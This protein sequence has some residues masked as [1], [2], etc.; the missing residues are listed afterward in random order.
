MLLDR[1]QV[2]AAG[3]AARQLRAGLDDRL[4]EPAAVRLLMDESPEPAIVLPAQVVRLLEEM[5]T[6]LANGN[7]VSLVPLQAELTTQQ[8]ADLL[9]VSRPYLVGLVEAGHIAHRR[10]G[11]RRRVPVADLL[12][13]RDELNE[14]TRDAA[15]ELTEQAQD[16]D[17]GYG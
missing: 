15:R 5:L 4:T 17:L 3:D 2:D 6:E 14:R 7:A 12:R 16:L 1:D 11:N 13:Y 9:G 8:A 10:V